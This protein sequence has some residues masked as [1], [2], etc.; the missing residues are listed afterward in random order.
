M[1]GKNE[2]S[3]GWSEIGRHEEREGREFERGKERGSQ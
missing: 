3:K 1:C 2:G